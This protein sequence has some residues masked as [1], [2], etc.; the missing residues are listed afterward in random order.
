MVL[1]QPS[2]QAVPSVQDLIQGQAGL[3]CILDLVQR[4]GELAPFTALARALVER[5]PRG[6]VHVPCELAF[7]LAGPRTASHIAMLANSGHRI[8]AD[9]QVAPGS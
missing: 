3:D 1:S 4:K 9:G 7:V 2:S 6:K 8:W 5:S